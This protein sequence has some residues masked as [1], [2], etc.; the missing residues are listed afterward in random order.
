ML[1]HVVMPFSSYAN[2][3]ILGKEFSNKG[4]QI[5]VVPFPR[6][7]IN[8]ERTHL[9]VGVRAESCY[10]VLSDFLITETNGSF[11][12]C[13]LSE[14]FPSDSKLDMSFQFAGSAC[15]LIELLGRQTPMLKISCA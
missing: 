9:A 6:V 10:D 4:V 8:P 3:I 15:L 13:P 1:L 2:S 5:N 14:G 12:T 11:A 7:R